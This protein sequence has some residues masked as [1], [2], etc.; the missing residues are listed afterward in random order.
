[1]LHA[2]GEVAA[3]R[4]RHR[5]LARI[6]GTVG[7][8]PPDAG[9]L[10]GAAEITRDRRQRLESLGEMVPHIALAAG[11]VDDHTRIEPV[12]GSAP[13]VLAV[14]PGR[15]LRQRASLVE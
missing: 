12:S 13:L 1:M 2:L 6:T 10:P 8:D 11:G 15:E 14:V 9:E 3:G 4:I 7:E 5:H